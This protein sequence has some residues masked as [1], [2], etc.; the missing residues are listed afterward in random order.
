M[1]LWEILDKTKL[2]HQ[3]NFRRT[4]RCRGGDWLGGG[5]EES[6]LEECQGWRNGSQFRRGW[7]PSSRGYGNKGRGKLIS[8]D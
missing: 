5:M 6:L 2:T 7:V 1:V 8:G 4:L 3:G